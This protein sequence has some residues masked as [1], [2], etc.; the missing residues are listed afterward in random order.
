MRGEGV[1]DEDGLGIYRA[2]ACAA[3]TCDFNLKA[4]ESHRSAFPF[5]LMCI[6]GTSALCQTPCQGKLEKNFQRKDHSEW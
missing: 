4:T 3:K 2:G 5:N 1:L 6:Y